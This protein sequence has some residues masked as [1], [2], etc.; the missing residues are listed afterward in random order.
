MALATRE[1]PILSLVTV[2][3]AALAE[4][5][6]RQHESA[7]LL[8]VAARLRGAHDHTDPQVRELT[9][10]GQAALGGE[11][12]ATAYT[13]GWELDGKTAVTAAGPGPATTGTQRERMTTSAKSGDRAARRPALPR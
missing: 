3:A 8:G 4:T 12:F 5:S 10:R 1:L 9:R 11:E 2:N 13:K 7:V 6:G